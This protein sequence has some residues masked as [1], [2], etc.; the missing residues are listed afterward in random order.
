MAR[1]KYYNSVTERW[2]AVDNTSAAPVQ[3]VNGKAGAVMLS[4]DDVGAEKAGAVAALENRLTTKKAQLTLEDGTVVLIDVYVASEGVKVQT[5]TNQMP[6]STD[7]SGA[8][9]NGQGWKGSYRLSGSAGTEKSQSTSALTGFIPVESGDVVRMRYDGAHSVFD[10]AT[11]DSANVIAYYDSTHTWL[12][13][14]TLQPSVYGICSNNDVPTGSLNTDGD[15]AT[16]T[17]PANTSIA[18]VRISMVTSGNDISDLI[19]TVNQE[20]EE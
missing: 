18:Y 9:Y 14:V 4:A 17:V 6:I 19:V 1:I 15:I 2:E 13:S 10:V 8:V 16:F 7:A 12:G 11:N 3:S 20:I 5:Y